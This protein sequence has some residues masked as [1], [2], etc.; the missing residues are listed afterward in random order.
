[1]ILYMIKYF[2]IMSISITLALSFHFEKHIK[3]SEVE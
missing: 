3:G 1:M 2:K